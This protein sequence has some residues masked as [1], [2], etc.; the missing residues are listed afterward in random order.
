[1]CSARARGGRARRGVGRLPVLAGRDD[2]VERFDA[3]LTRLESGQHGRGLIYSGLRGVGKTVLL[4]EVEKLA[5]ER[6]WDSTGVVEIGATTDFRTS[7][8]R[9]TR[10]R[11]AGIG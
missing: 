1:M 5:A 10:R 3:L 7:I 6:G 8:A 2:D 4:L 9:M 11:F